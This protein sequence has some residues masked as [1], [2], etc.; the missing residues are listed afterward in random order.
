MVSVD[1]G[2]T[3]RRFANPDAIEPRFSPDNT[4]VAYN[5]VGKWSGDVFGEVRVVRLSDNSDFPVTRVPARFRSPAWSPDGGM[6]A[7]LV[8]PDK[9]DL[10]LQELWI[11]AV[12]QTGKAAS[13]P[14]RIRLPRL[15]GSIAGWTAD[16][17]IGLLSTSPRRNA[18]YTVPLSGGKATQATP[19]G[20]TYNPQWSPDGERIYFR[21]GLGDIAYVPARGGTIH[22]VPRTGEMVRVSLPNGGNHIS[23]DG[24]RIV[25][26]GA[27]DG[28]R[29]V[30][31]WTM[32][33][34]GGEPLR[35]PMKPDL[36]SFQPRWSPDGKWIAFESE[37]DV[38]GDRKLDENIFIVSSEGG[39]PRQ[40]TSHADCFCE[41]LAWSPV[42]DSIA[43]ACT[44]QVIRIVPVRGGE[45][46]TVLKADGLR[47]RSNSLAWT[48]DGSQLIYSAKGRLWTVPAGGGEPTA[49][50]TD[51]DG[52][53]QQFALSPDGRTIAFNVPT[54]GDLELWLMEDFLHLVKAD[55]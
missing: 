39:E 4:Y 20:D 41:M 51:L 30:H 1:T 42:G 21:W 16:N 53:I 25:W 15:T 45:P 54:G 44:D 10:S 12:S 36:N 26:A 17:K 29:G 22:V 7:F 2:E 35:L 5:R 40:L 33:V 32:P 27:R 47:P 55:R 8:Q 14:A 24:N 49:I 9:N 23:P 31:L 38:E 11:A 46:R 19:E 34:S 37:R 13:E 52:N 48:I 6:L 50:S 18:I 3:V 28:M 43:Y